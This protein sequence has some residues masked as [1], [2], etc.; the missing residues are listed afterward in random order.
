MRD[1]HVE[2]HHEPARPEQPEAVRADDELD[3][4]MGEVWPKIEAM[5]LVPIGYAIV[6]RV[7][8]ELLPAL[9]DSYVRTGGDLEKANRVTQIA[10]DGWLS[11][12]L[13]T[14]DL[15]GPD[16]YII[17]K[18]RQLV[19]SLVDRKFRELMKPSS[20]DG[21]IQKKTP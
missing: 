21:L 4:L 12:L 3:A 20:G 8:G 15:P 18:I 6:Q 16:A 13:S 19:V 17:P 10:V 11:Q 5:Q 14:V 7:K 9:V 2:R 1:G